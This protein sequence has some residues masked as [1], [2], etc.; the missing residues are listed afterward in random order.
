MTQ[1]TGIAKK[2]IERSARHNQLNSLDT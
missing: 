1:I 2:S